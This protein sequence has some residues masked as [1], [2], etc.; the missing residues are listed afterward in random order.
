[1]TNYFDK[2]GNYINCEN[3]SLA[4][5]YKRGA[6]EGYKKGY[7]DGALGSVGDKS[8]TESVS[9]ITDNLYDKLMRGGL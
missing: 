4:E 1:M 9:A 6:A 7:I 3:L 5:I 2:N 8:E